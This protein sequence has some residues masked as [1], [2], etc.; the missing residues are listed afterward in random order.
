MADGA[1]EPVTQ[2]SILVVIP[3]LNEAAHIGGLLDQLR[4]AA[5]R[6]S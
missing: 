5:A 3:C 2:A 1:H 4:P 6:V